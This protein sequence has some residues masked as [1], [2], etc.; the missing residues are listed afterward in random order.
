M[1]LFIEYSQEEVEYLLSLVDNSER[2]NNLLFKG[3]SIKEIESICAYFSFEEL[4]EKKVIEDYDL[5]FIVEGCVV[6]IK[7]KK[8]V[9]KYLKN[10]IIGIESCFFKRE[11]KSLITIKKSK[12]IFFKIKNIHNEITSKF[13]KNLFLLYASKFS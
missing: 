5:I 4:P 6:E 11:K 12:L 2:L 7:D 1:N 9:K 10:D 13:Y 3:M 8:I